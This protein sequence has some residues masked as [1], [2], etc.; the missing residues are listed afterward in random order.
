MPSL[1]TLTAP[2]SARKAHPLSKASTTKRVL[3]FLNISH[4][5]TTMSACELTDQETE[6]KEGA[7]SPYSMATA[8]KESCP[9]RNEFVSQMASFSLD[10]PSTGQHKD[11]HTVFS[12]EKNS[13][14]MTPEQR[15]KHCAAVQKH[16]KEVI[17]RM[18]KLGAG[19][20][21]GN[22]PIS[23][24][25]SSHSATVTGPTANNRAIRKPLPQEKASEELNVG[26]TQASGKGTASDPSTLDKESSENRSDQHKSEL[27]TGDPTSQPKPV[28]KSIRQYFMDLDIMGKRLLKA[29]AT[30]R[31]AR[32]RA[33]KRNHTLRC[34]TSLRRKQPDYTGPFTP[35]VVRRTK[36]GLAKCEQALCSASH[37]LKP[38]RSKAR[39][40]VLR[41]TGQGEG[42]EKV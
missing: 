35:R 36:L 40:A 8:K 17:A 6:P 4:R 19:D 11:F 20:R 27:G 39:Q 21:E 34:V 2:S 10:E 28:P 24:P 41:K 22:D 1:P 3:G 42:Y 31:E 12:M 29:R 9:P 26:D 25:F 5:S 18:R 32:T 33:Y 15:K 14:T 23:V 30:Y 38:A 13:P 7:S 16:R 37:D